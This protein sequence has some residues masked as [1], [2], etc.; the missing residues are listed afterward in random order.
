MV[1]VADVVQFLKKEYFLVGLVLLMLLASIDPD[2]GRSEGTWS[3]SIYACCTWSGLHVW[4][5]S[6]STPLLSWMDGSILGL[7]A[8][9]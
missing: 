9:C 5:R 4:A 2:I 3:V 6:G 7:A 8:I 1:D